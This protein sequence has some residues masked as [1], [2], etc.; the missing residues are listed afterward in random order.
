MSQSCL[1]K[2]KDAL[3]GQVQIEVADNFKDGTS[4]TRVYFYSD[5]ILSDQRDVLH[6]TDLQ[7]NLASEDTVKTNRAS[8]LDREILVFNFN[9]VGLV[10][11][12]P[13][14]R[15]HLR[16]TNPSYYQRTT[17]YWN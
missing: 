9:K 5:S 12:E 1:P 3:T 8:L 11:N 6:F 4:E 2:L 10:E 14:F 13:S 15:G 16:H 17:Y 7:E